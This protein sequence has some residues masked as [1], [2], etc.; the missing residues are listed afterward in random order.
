MFEA[1]HRLIL[2]LARRDLIQGLRID[3]VDGLTEPKAYLER[4]QQRLAEVRPDAAPFYVVV[5]KILIGDEQLPDGLAGRRHHRLR[6][7][8]RGRW[9]CWSHRRGLDVLARA[10]RASSPARRAGLS[11]AGPRGQG[12]GAGAAVRRRARR[13]WRAGG[14]VLCGLA[15]DDGRRAACASCCSAFPVYRTYGGDELGGG[16]RRACCASVRSRPPSDRGPGRRRRP[17]PPGARLARP[18]AGR[19]PRTLLW[20]LQQLSGPLMAKSVEDT[21]F[22]RYPRLL[23]LNEVGGEPDAPGLRAGG[24]P[25]PARSVGWSDGPA[26]AGDRDPRHQARRGRPRPA[27]GAERAAGRMGRGGARLARAERALPIDPRSSQGRV[28]ALP[29]AGRRV[30]A[31]A[32]AR[33]RRRPRGSCASAWRA[34]CSRRCARARSA[35]TGTSPTR[36]TSGA[37]TLVPAAASWPRRVGVPVAR[38]ATS[39]RRIAPAGVAN[40][41]ASSW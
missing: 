22:Y 38:C 13:P 18:P 1:S 23:A 41:L 37:A 12:R 6:V 39:S 30:A 31:G 19:R 20:G 10:G 25:P 8:E 9:A 24:V 17:G 7:H 5:E 27:R 28:R 32:G 29:V 34:G 15:E 40:S 33:R 16:G 36:P 4:L 3:H 14:R 26:A 11:R 35:P 21:A 2:D